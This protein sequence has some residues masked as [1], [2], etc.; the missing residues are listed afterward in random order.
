MRTGSLAMGLC[1]ALGCTLL[2][3][4]ASRREPLV[5][6]G[7]KSWKLQEEDMG[8][9]GPG[10][11]RKACWPGPGRRGW[12]GC[13]RKV[14][15]FPCL[16]LGYRSGHRGRGASGGPLCPRKALNGEQILGAWSPPA[17]GRP[18]RGRQQEE[19]YMPTVGCRGD[20]T[21]K[22][23]SAC[24]PHHGHGLA[25]PSDR[26]RGQA[27]PGQRGEPGLTPVSGPRPRA[28]G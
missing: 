15:S 7:G 28:A 22:C 26:Q 5:Y 1:L 24:H 8:G 13:R 4:G 27:A 14:A 25:E 17:P 11:W 21:G 20:K 12:A 19:A 2:E 18:G 23:G 16:Q 10:S 3:E 6:W 9:L